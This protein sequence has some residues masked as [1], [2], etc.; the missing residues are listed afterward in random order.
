MNCYAC[1]KDI[2]TASICIWCGASQ[3]VSATA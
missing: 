3:D 2:G 1:E